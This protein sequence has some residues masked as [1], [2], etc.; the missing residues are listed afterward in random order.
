MN[1]SAI[2]FG[3]VLS[4]FVT[5]EDEYLLAAA[6]TQLQKLQWWKSKEC[7]TENAVIG[8]P[9]VHA[10]PLIRATVHL[11]DIGLVLAR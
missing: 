5:V 1:G 2:R 8:I 11:P 6:T 3:F 10:L 9:L 4:G 7:E